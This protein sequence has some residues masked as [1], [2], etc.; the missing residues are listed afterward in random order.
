M[1]LLRSVMGSAIVKRNAAEQ[2]RVLAVL[3]D[4][5][6]VRESFKF[7]LEIEGFEVHAYASPDKLLSD[8]ERLAFDCFIVDYHLPGTNGLDVVDQLRKQGSS[9]PAILVTGNPDAK[10]RKRAS[11]AAVTLIEKSSAAA[12]LL[13][14]IRRLVGAS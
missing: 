9:A 10:I 13:E 5:R 1:P 11:A 2:G 6:A 7:S 4:D 12:T 8:P 14:N 3:E